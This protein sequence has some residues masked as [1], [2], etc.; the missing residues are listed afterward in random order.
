[1]TKKRRGYGVKKKPPD[2]KHRMAD[3]EFGMSHRYE[4]Y[5]TVPVDWKYCGVE[6]MKFLRAT[7]RITLLR[8]ESFSEGALFFE[9][10]GEDTFFGLAIQ[11]R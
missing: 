9:M 7:M 1:M 11:T 2:G 10:K 5:W 6:K 4:K 3:S 8:K